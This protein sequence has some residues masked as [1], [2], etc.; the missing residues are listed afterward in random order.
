MEREISDKRHYTPLDHLLMGVDV[1]LRT[2][3]GPPKITERA[4]P[5]RNQQE[6]ELNEADRELAG[7]LMRINH[8]GEVAAQGLYQ[9]QALTA[10][11]PQVREKM[12]RAALEENDHLDWCER[13]AKELGT[14]VSYLNPVWYAGSVAIGA[15]AG[16]AGDKW[17]LGFVAE[18]EHQVVKHLDEHLEQLPETDIRSRAILEQMKE[19][20]GHH[21]TVALEAGGTELPSPVKKLMGLTSKIMTRT[22]FWI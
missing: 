21:A 14:H 4:N 7:R 19:D 6:A 12:E 13:R 3:L 1:G 8:A 11:L 5:A 15:L 16:I 2:L 20:E 9:G 18:T 22:A 17:S 10:N